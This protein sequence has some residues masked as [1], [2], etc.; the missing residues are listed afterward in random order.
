MF[1]ILFIDLPNLRLLDLSFNNLRSIGQDAFTGLSLDYLFLGDNPSIMLPPSGFTQMSTG[2]IDLKNCRL[3]EISPAFLEPLVSSLRKLFING[4]R[5]KRFSPELLSAFSGLE[6]IRIQENPLVC[7]CQSRWLKLFYDQNTDKIRQP[8][9]GSQTEPRC[10]EP[11]SLIGSF[12][13]MLSS[14]DFL[15]DK[16]SLDSEITFSDDKGVLKCTSKASPPPKISWYRP[17]GAVEETSPTE[18]E[19]TRAQI[20]VLPSQTGTYKCVASNEAG[21]ISLAFN[22]TWPH[23]A[24]N[25]QLPCLESDTTTAKEVILTNPDQGPQ[26]QSP[27]VFKRKYFTIIDIVISVF[28]TFA[29]TLIVTVVVLHICVYRKRKSASQYSTP[30]QSDYSG[31]SIKNEVYPPPSAQHLQIRSMPHMQHMQN[32][33]LPN[34]PCHKA[35]D[36]NHYM[37]TQLGDGDDLVRFGQQNAGA[38]VSPHSPVPCQCQAMSSHHRHSQA[39]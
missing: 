4:N 39:L 36:E 15:C 17:D 3:T 22:M 18:N 19:V 28:G 35:Y 13:N 10:S 23:N 14:M 7:D 21:N 29:G 9:D 25:N 37:S 11:L 33:P 1:L 34:E 31:G 5:I 27:D 16:P 26:T 32:R 8:S 20:E 24:R 12:F 38:I 2:I 30:P 6:S